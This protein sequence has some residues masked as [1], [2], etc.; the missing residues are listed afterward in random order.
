[1][2]L[3]RAEGTVTVMAQQRHSS[4]TA[5]IRLLRLLGTKTSRIAPWSHIELAYHCNSSE[6]TCGIAKVVHYAAHD[7]DVCHG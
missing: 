3:S 4:G 6:K 2:A 5:T 7:H 1:M